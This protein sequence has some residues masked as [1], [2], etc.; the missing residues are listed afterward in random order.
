[1]R[2]RVLGLLMATV[3]WGCYSM[4]AGAAEL[5]QEPVAEYQKI[6]VDDDE[7]YT[8]EDMAADCGELAERFGL[9]LSSLGET[10]C[11]RHVMCL[12]YGHGDINILVSAGI[13]AREYYNPYL[14]MQLLEDF[15]VEADD[16][17]AD[18]ITMYVIPMINPDGVSISQF[19]EEAVPESMRDI[20]KLCYENDKSK[21]ATSESYE[22]YLR[23]WKSNA[24]GVDLNRNFTVGFGG[25][26]SKDYLSGTACKGEA[27]LDQVESKAIAD[28][29]DRI[30]PDV[31]LSLHSYGE[32][33]FDGHNTHSKKL[34]RIL[35]RVT[36]YVYNTSPPNGGM[37]EQMLTANPECAC[38]TLETSNVSCPFG[39]KYNSRIYKKTKDV[40]KLT[41]D[42]ARE[43]MKHETAVV[44]DATVPLAS[45]DQIAV[46]EQAM[47]EQTMSDKEIGPVLSD[48]ELKKILEQFR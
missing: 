6:V 25:S 33:Y 20:L 11:G 15:L 7:M 12:T 42:Y 9:D 17:V 8:Y 1:M 30:C 44:A 10:A 16:T 23:R 38:V 36:G 24:L 29:A 46:V 48:A 13:H 14:L 19:G 22:K 45:E 35:S 41:I 31:S 4:S 28:L 32:V 34:S 47:E 21:G 5:A 40:L 2:K 3:V 39:N 43:N 26:G 27:P 18:E 37:L